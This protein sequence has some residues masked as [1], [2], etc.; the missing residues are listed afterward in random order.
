MPKG[1]MS[2]M[3]NNRFYDRTSTII[4]SCGKEY[5][6]K[7]SKMVSSLT[8]LHKKNCLECRQSTNIHLGVVDT[9]AVLDKQNTARDYFVKEI[10]KQ[11]LTSNST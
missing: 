3:L 6:S 1:K 4:L 11:L 2:K 9:I 8:R 10:A 7:N 5:S